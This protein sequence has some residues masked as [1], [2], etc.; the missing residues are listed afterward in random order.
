MQ[1]RGQAVEILGT[2]EIFGHKTAWVRFLE[3][4]RFEQV[5]HEELEAEV[6]NYS[7][8]FV[9]YIA[10][11]TK[12]KDEVAKKNILAPYESSLLPLPHQILVL[13]KVMQSTHNRLRKRPTRFFET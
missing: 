2:K 8:A 13:E 9:R 4:G 1:Y 11:A 12:I 10:I 5:A 7:H 6:S 3:D